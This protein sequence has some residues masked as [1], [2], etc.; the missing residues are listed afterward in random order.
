MGANLRYFFDREMTLRVTDD[1]LEI[2]VSWRQRV[3]DM[4]NYLPLAF[5]CFD[6]MIN[7]IRIPFRQ[8]FVLICICGAYM[9]L[10]SINQAFLDFSPFPSNL[11]YHCRENWSSLA[12]NASF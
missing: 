6:F 8:L 9:S 12:Y 1:D 2:N 5:L 3:L 4:A 11:A 7:K 10:T